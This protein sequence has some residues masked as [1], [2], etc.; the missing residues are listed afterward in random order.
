MKVSNFKSGI[1]V[2]PL[3]Q[4][5]AK[6]SEAIK[7]KWQQWVPWEVAVRKGLDNSLHFVIHASADEPPRHLSHLY[8]VSN[9]KDIEKVCKNIARKYKVISTEEY[10]DRLRYGELGEKNVLATVSCD[11]GLREFKAYLWPIMKKYSIPCTLF[12]VKNFVERKEYFYR[13]KAS[14]I[15]EALEDSEASKETRNCLEKLGKNV[16]PQTSIKRTIG[17]IRHPKDLWIF[18][19]LLEHLNIDAETYFEKTKPFLDRSEVIELHKDGVRLG[20]HGVHHYR[21]DL[22]SSDDV[23]ADIL[24]GVTYIQ[25]LSGQ[26]TVE[27]AFPF[28]GRTISRKLLHNLL[29]RQPSLT[30]FF[31]TGGIRRDEPFV[32]HRVILDSKRPQ[33]ALRIAAYEYLN[34]K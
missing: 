11:D 2:P 14:L 26:M 9:P 12:L 15:S 1:S 6:Y 24:N 4:F 8:P 16:D 10:V 18:D 22:I 7:E 29:L 17:Q 3:S 27:H 19:K 30:H 5:V 13:F 34:T 33:R 23:E 21:Y 31:D 25:N 28:N 32:T 20:S